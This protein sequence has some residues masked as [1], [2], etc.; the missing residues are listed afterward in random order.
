[1]TFF[2]GDRPLDQ[3]APEQ[4]G[5]LRRHAGGL[6]LRADVGDDFF[7]TL[8]NRGGQI[9]PRLDLHHPIETPHSLASNA[10]ISRSIRSMVAR[11]SDKAC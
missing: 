6:R 2:I 9:F 4:L 5:Q 7:D 11:N 10:T 3:P 1:M 8:G